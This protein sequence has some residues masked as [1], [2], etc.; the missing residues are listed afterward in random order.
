MLDIFEAEPRTF[1]QFVGNIDR[2]LLLNHLGLPRNKLSLHC[3]TKRMVL[4]FYRSA[5]YLEL[6]LDV[7]LS[8]TIVWSYLD[9]CNKSTFRHMSQFVL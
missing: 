2:N 4:P 9:C 7:G 6:V 5:L 1:Y 8:A 3:S